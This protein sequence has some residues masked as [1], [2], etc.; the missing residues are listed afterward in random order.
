[1]NDK[2]NEI[3]LRLLTNGKYIWTINVVFDEGKEDLAIERVRQLD[4]KLKDKFPNYPTVG[5]NRS[6]SLDEE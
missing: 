4:I 2:H 3:T 6:V 5:G 1:M